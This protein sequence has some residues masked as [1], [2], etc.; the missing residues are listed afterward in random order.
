MGKAERIL[1]S[2]WAIHALAT[3]TV[4]GTLSFVSAASISRADTPSVTAT[5]VDPQFA[6]PFIDV[7]EWR[8]APVRHR[9][10]HGGFKGTDT[11]FAIYFPPKD[12]F[13]R[14]FFQPIAATTGSE[15]NAQSPGNLNI[16]FAID[17]GGYLVESNQGRTDM[18]SGADGTL[19]YRASAAV[20]KYSRSLAEQMYGPGKIYGYAW[21]GSGGGFKT[22]SMAQMTEGVWDG[23]VPYIIG[24]PM[25]LPNVFSVQAH[26]LRILKL[27]MPQIVDALDAG[28]S[29]DPYAGLNAE[30]V[31]ALHEASRMG[32][33][34]GAWFDYQRLGYGP[35]AVL[36]DDMVRW[37]PTY[38]ADFWTKPGYEGF[39]PP[40]SLKAARIQQSTTISKV[41]MSNEARQ[42]GLPVPMAAIAAT[43][44]VAAVQLADLP[45]KDLKGASLLIK[46]GGAAGQRVSISTV[47]G[48][49]VILGIG[50]DAYKV[51]NT[52]KPGDQV[53][54]DNSIYLAAQTYQRHQVPTRDFYVFDQYRKPDGTPIY[55]QR[56]Q[57]LGPKYS[58]QGAGSVQDGTFH[59]KMIVVASLQDEMA[60]PWQADW[61]RHK[62]ESVLGPQTDQNFRL[63]YTQNALHGGPVTR[64]G[65]DDNPAATRIVVY[66]GILHQALR[67]LSAWVERGVAPPATT[68]YQVIDGQVIPAKT[69]A[70]RHGVQPVVTA[71][72]NG[73]TRAVAH[74]GQPITLTGTVE[75]P[76][77]AGKV[78]A[79][80]WDFDG[81][82]TYPAKAEFTA[83][84]DGTRAT[85]TT[86]HAFD[87][88]GTYF[89]VLRATS[90]RQGDAN[91]PYARIQ[92]LA[93]VRVV[94]E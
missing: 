43:P 39:N 74:P 64:P 14:R 12:R 30:E 66:T 45:Q 24:S 94:V 15:L 88:P 35:L 59:G 55:P 10:I 34:L 90:Q 71:M 6:Q 23:T 42:Q 29:G 63:W 69:A 81:K 86:T 26:A 46:S 70:R 13:Q 1:V 41:V 91:T 87:R 79:T 77:G 33:P 83:N 62:V 2:K 16:G 5:S 17:S 20:A 44:L 68:G 7:D 72:A 57:I 47:V 54:V 48:S 60:Y 19:P 92:N 11:K 56:P 53:T 52:L 80:E 85:V 78:V 49:N 89:P 84:A 31:D 93:R 28:G 67:D 40:E 21:G 82:G 4:L 8:D 22:I 3:A 25:A 27:K 58:V 9:Y 73:A 18:Y 51:I 38:F 36:I 50:A 61:Y 76:P 32:M 75:V 65:Q 37:D